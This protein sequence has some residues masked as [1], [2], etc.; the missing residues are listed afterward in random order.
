[1]NIDQFLNEY[2]ERKD[3]PKAFEKICRE[4]GISYK[5]LRKLLK[6]YGFEYDPKSHEWINKENKDL[7]EVDLTKDIPMR[8]QRKQPVSDKE[9]EH[10]PDIPAAEEEHKQPANGAYEAHEQIASAVHVEHEQ[11]ARPDQAPHKQRAY[12]QPPFDGHNYV[13]A[14]QMVDIVDLLQQINQKIPTAAISKNIEIEEDPDAAPLALQLHNISQD[15]KAR[16]T[17]NVTEEAAKWLDS[18]SETKGYRIG[19]IVSL[20]IMQLKKRIDP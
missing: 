10:K 16:K 9:K 4:N 13:L 1:M 7:P 12:E 20:A 18:F 2:Q 11:H 14:D 15:I 3:E 19:D 6:D 5:K 17:L 8:V